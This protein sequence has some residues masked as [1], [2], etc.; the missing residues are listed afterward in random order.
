[1]PIDL[2]VKSMVIGLSIAAPVGPIGLL[3]I[4]RS[5]QHGPML[6]FISG[7]GA[8]VADALYGCIAAFGLTAISSTLVQHETIL[9]FVG[10]LFLCYLGART[11]LAHDQKG[12]AEPRVSGRWQAFGSTLFLTFANPMTIIAFAGVFA[13]LGRS[14]QADSYFAASAMVLGVFLGSA[15]WWIF[16]SVA[17]GF[18]RDRVG[19]KAMI[20]IN[21]ISGLTIFAFGVVAITAAIVG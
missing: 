17:A 9:R 13:V 8:A 1:M 3:C 5:I 4:R 7:L 2:F 6:G 19:D 18:L 20:V 11:F 16:L 12:E 15:A 10:G 21:R 14:A